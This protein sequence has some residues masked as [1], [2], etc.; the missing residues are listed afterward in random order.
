MI[1]RGCVTRTAGIGR[2]TVVIA[3][4]SVGAATGLDQRER[5][6]SRAQS[7]VIC[8]VTPLV[9]LVATLGHGGQNCEVSTPV[10]R[11]VT[12]VKQSWSSCTLYVGAGDLAGTRS[13]E[14]GDSQQCRRQAPVFRSFARPSPGQGDDRAAHLHEYDP[15]YPHVYPSG[16]MGR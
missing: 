3:T 6:G 4:R 5:R 16:R 13:I 12:S 9:K 1:S 2:K 8:S 14:A 7:L 10:I 15:F 11:L